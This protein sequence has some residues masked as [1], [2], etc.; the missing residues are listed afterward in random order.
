MNGMSR[1]RDLVVLTGVASVVTSSAYV[2]A[3]VQKAEPPRGAI[4]VRTQTVYVKA[5]A[6]KADAKQKAEALRNAKEKEVVRKRVFARA[7]PLRVAGAAGLDAQAA[8]YIQQFR[9]IFRTEY[10]FVRSACDLS[11]DQRKQLAELGERTIKSAAK[12]FV[13]DQQKMMRGG[14]RP[15]VQPPDPHKLIEQELLKS[16]AS[17]LTQD[18]ERRYKEEVEKRTASRRQVAADNIVARIDQDLVLT[19]DQRTR[20]AEALVAHWDD[21]W[22]QSLEMLTNI[23]NFLPNIPDNVVMPIL[24]ESQR[25]GWRRMSKNQGVFFGVSFGGMVQEN[26]PLDDPELIEARK[27]ADAQEIK[28]KR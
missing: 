5:A 20:L 16:A 14:W 12:Q 22:V 6:P 15:G 8:Q 2:L 24:A 4:E 21:S 7:V 28:P 11:K 19:S 10:Y 3:Q 13:E 26:D 23:D 17:F 18:Q 25:D 9:P 1:L 27:N